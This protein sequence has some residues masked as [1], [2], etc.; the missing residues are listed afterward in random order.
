[1]EKGDEL[2]RKLVDN[3]LESLRYYER[4]DPVFADYYIE[5]IR[6][7]LALINEM[8]NVAAKF[9]RNELS[10]SLDDTLEQEFNK[11]MQYF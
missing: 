4:L 7:N 2:I 9:K 1:M 6:E 10:L 11:F 3:S 5:N 8:S